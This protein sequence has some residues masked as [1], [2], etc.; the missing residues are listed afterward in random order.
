MTQTHEGAERSA[1][2][3]LGIP[4]EEY[5]RRVQAGDKHC[6]RCREWHQRTAFGEDSTRYDGLSSSCLH[7]RRVKV[8]AKRGPSPKRGKR[9]VAP[10]AGDKKQ[11]RRWVNYL[12]ETGLLPNPNAL[13]CVDCGH[14]CKQGERRHEY[15]HNK[16]YAPEHHGRVDPVCTSCHHKRHHG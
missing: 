6:G 2:K 7:S 5:R 8:R 13:A 3:K 15:D 1:A 16:G 11:A 12:V 9:L 14:V 4:T 10:R